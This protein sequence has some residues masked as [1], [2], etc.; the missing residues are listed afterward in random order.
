MI[1]RIIEA[2]NGFN[3]G[4][5]MVG[6]FDAGEWGYR[7]CVDPA[8]RRLLSARGWGWEHFFLMDIETGE[9]GMFGHGGHAASD[10]N[11]R[12]RIW[13]CPLFGPFLD[14][15]YRQDM[16]GWGADL[17]GLPA[18]VALPA[19]AAAMFGYRRPGPLYRAGDSRSTEAQDGDVRYGTG[20]WLER[21]DGG[22]WVQLRCAGDPV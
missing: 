6:I 8:A 4:K 18:K 19:D 21:Y 9:G 12:H 10:L 5:F 15:L 16:A 20:D 14:W 7:S 2:G 17:A 13:V 22:T 11:D 3:W 1:T